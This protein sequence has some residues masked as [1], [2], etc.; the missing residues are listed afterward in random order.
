[1]PDIKEY[2]MVTEPAKPDSRLKEL[3]LVCALAVVGIALTG[4][5]MWL[6]WEVYE[7]L[8]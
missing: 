4:V 5:V 1:M 3:A 6:G 7:G 8:P 2:I